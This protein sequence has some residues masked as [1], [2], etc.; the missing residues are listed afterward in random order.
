MTFQSLFFLIGTLLLLYISRR[1]LH[2]PVSH[3]FFRFFAFETTLALVAI[4]LPPWFRDPFSLLHLLSWLLLIASAFMALHGYFLLRAIGKPGADFE[5]TTVLV[6]KGAYRFIRHP[7]YSS[8]LY[9][10]LGAFLKLPSLPGAA[11]LL[12]LL[13]FLTLTARVEES[14]NLAKFGPP[15]AAYMRRTT[16]FIPYIF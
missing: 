14:E 4:N 11:L 3:G 1:S 8:L 16:R 15:Y 2:L 12:A 7:M 6:E 9:L 5:T 13:A 10:G